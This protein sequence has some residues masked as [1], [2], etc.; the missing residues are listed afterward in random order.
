MEKAERPFP[1]IADHIYGD[2]T[3]QFLASRHEYSTS[4]KT[5]ALID[6]A[7]ADFK[8]E[9]VI[10]EGMATNSPKGGDKDVQQFF[11]DLVLKIKNKTPDKLGEPQYALLLAQEKNIVVFSGEPNVFE[12]MDHLRTKGYTNDDY[13][14]MDF[15]LRIGNWQQEG[16]TAQDL[17]PL[18]QRNSHS[19]QSLILPGFNDDLAHFSDWFKRWTGA[20]FSLE[21]IDHYFIAPDVTQPFGTISHM[22]GVLSHFRDITILKTIETA[23]N[24]HKRV[25]IIYGGSHYWTLQP[26]L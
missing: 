22:D 10:L 9:A 14:C 25:L 20:E 13:A 5:H 26:A 6:N 18:W 24:Q 3:L 11:V 21:M 15:L 23:L 19:Y 4:S 8:P 1:F 7:F 16:L 2:R 17:S 12:Q